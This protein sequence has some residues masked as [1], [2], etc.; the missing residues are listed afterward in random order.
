MTQT[1]DL[2][3]THT[4]DGLTVSLPEHALGEGCL[5]AT[6]DK[7]MA[8][9]D[10]LGASELRLDF[11]QITYLGSSGLGVLVTLH[12]RTKQAGGHLVLINLAPYLVELFKLTRLDTILDVRPAEAELQ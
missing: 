12:R 9:A 7:L 6:R 8:L 3:V 11:A 1:S 10:G 2:H 4:A 5:E